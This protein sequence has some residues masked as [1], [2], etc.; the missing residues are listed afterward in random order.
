MNEI[1]MEDDI[2]DVFKGGGGKMIV[3][4]MMMEDEEEEIKSTVEGTVRKM[5]E[6][7]N[8]NLLFNNNNK[9]LV[10]TNQKEQTFTPL[11]N[12]LF[13]TPTPTIVG[14][15]Q[16]KEEMINYLEEE[17][18]KEEIVQTKKKEGIKKNKEEEE[19]RDPTRIFKTNMRK[20]N[21]L[22]M[23]NVKIRH[24]TRREKFAEA[25]EDRFYSSLQYVFEIV[26]DE[27]DFKEEVKFIHVRATVEDGKN[28]TKE[29][30]YMKTETTLVK[31]PGDENQH[32]LRGELCIQLSNVLS[33]HKTKTKFALTLSFAT[34]NNLDEPFLKKTSPTFAVYARKPGKSVP[35][36][37]KKNVQNKKKR[38]REE[39]ME[40]L[41]DLQTTTKMKKKKPSL[42]QF[43]FE[44]MKVLKIENE[45]KRSL[46]I[47][48]VYDTFIR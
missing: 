7:D 22:K 9:T 26:M 15:K 41:F 46:A 38:K 24:K 36:K 44:L 20:G 17:G 10:D 48:N 18:K 34:S 37:K 47:E 14:N 27:R 40:D 6:G 42:K 8:F 39:T 43:E 16:M 31:H 13:W 33:Y 5:E 1:M 2:F 23:D 21:F 11:L 45:K 19:K 29:P 32:E 35:K 25:M 3:N 30:I 12:G 4:T 28:Y